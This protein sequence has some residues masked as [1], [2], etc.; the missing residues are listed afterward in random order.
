MAKK[1]LG[2]DWW[3]GIMKLRESVN[4]FECLAKETDDNF[5]KEYIKN[6]RDE[7]AS[8]IRYVADN[9]K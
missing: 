7:E 5:L 9:Y 1:E 6:L 4:F 8:L 3:R 2:A